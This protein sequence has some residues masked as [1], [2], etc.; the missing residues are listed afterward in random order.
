LKIL[1]LALPVLIGLGLPT[2]S[3]SGISLGAS[4]TRC[5]TDQEIDEADRKAIEATAREFALDMI[6][7][8]FEDAYALMSSAAKQAVTLDN[9]KSTEE[10]LASFGLTS[11]HLDVVHTYF[12]TVLGSVGSKKNGY[13]TCTA[14]AGGSGKEP[15]GSVGMHVF[16]AERQ[17]VALLRA[18]TVDNAVT[19]TISLI[20]ENSKWSVVYMHAGDSEISGLTSEALLAAAE[21]EAGD[22]HSLNAHVLYATAA[23]LAYRGPNFQLGVA[24]Q[25]DKAFKAADVPKEIE[26]D[27]PW[28]WTFGGGSFQVTNLGMIGI[29]GK[30]YLTIRQVIADW[31]EDSA[32][33]ARNREMIAA[34]VEHF[35]EYRGAFAGIVAEA[36]DEGGTKGFRTV[37]AP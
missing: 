17:G 3:W 13:T 34:F 18:Q 10:A 16:P 15:Q 32:A 25:I 33:D 23:Q 7:S 22:G 6:T 2:K 26:G 20:N 37:S 14:E 9:L 36:V 8:K 31:S 1:C 28:E 11:D 35:P 12:V 24:S 27:G 30:I 4:V 19:F 21:K 5:E 29:G